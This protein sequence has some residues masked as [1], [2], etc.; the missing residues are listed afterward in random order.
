MIQTR[1]LPFVIA[2]VILLLLSFFY[3]IY[4]LIDTDIGLLSAAAFLLWSVA[5]ADAFT[6][7]K[8]NII[9]IFF[10]FTFFCFYYPEQ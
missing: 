10:L 8:R 2:K 9:Y 6:R 1:R 7:R 5:L 4:G 3:M